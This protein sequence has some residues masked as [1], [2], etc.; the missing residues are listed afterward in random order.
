MRNKL[1]ICLFSGTK[2]DETFPNR[3]FKIYGYKLYCR[4]RNKHGGGVLCY[5]NENNSSKMV[6]V[7]GVPDTVK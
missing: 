2:L 7:E 1:D 5:V 6:S 3:Q 4:D